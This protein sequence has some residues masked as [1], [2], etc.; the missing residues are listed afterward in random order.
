MSHN[1]PDWFIPKFRDAYKLRGE[2][3]KRRLDGLAEEGGMFIGDDCHFPRFGQAETTKSSR[4]QELI[5]QQVPLDWVKIAAE[6]EFVSFGIWDPDKKK[7]NIS[8]ANAF[9]GAAVRSVNRAR[10]RQ[11]IDALRLAA[12]NGVT[13]TKG[14]TENIITIGDYDTVV[15]LETICDAIVRLAEDEMFEGESVS[16]IS[17]FKVRMNMS[18]DPYLAKRDMKENRPWD[19]VNWRGYERL[20]GNGAN[21]AG[22]TAAGA[23]GVDLFVHAKSAVMTVA[24]DEDTEINER[25]GS[26]MGDLIGRWFQTASGVVEPKGVIRIRSKLDFELFRRAIP[27][28]D[29]SE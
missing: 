9:A 8:M 21:G 16:V 14:Q 20:P 7:L 11:H 6:P 17:P 24:N 19:E 3:K 5:M 28:I 10:D 23:T 12:T 18:L 27:I 4:L 29:T 22:W 13:N 2:Q 1:L 25:L 26:R 15:D